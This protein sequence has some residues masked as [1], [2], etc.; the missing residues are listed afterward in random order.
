M[1]FTAVCKEP[2][3]TSHQLKTKRAQLARAGCCQMSPEF[4]ARNW[5]MM[6]VPRQKKELAKAR[7]RPGPQGKSDLC[8]QRDDWTSDHCHCR[9]HWHLLGNCSCGDNTAEVRAHLSRD[10]Y[11]FGGGIPRRFHVLTWAVDAMFSYRAVF[12][13]LMCRIRRVVSCSDFNSRRHQ[14]QGDK[15][16][17]QGSSFPEVVKVFVVRS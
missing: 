5:A 10:L 8:V 15:I 14:R 16:P 11:A 12:V 9:C 13:F 4:R 7:A 2:L 1:I 6:Q 17:T 3:Q